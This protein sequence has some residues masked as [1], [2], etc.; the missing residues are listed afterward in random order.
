M[1]RIANRVFGVVAGLLFLTAGCAQQPVDKS[2]DKGVSTTNEVKKQRTEASLTKA[3]TA[4]RKPVAE[5]M[6]NTGDTYQKGEVTT[7]KP[8]TI[9]FTLQLAKTSNNVDKEVL[10][11]VLI[12]GIKP[13]AD[14]IFQVRPGTKLRV[15]LLNP[16]QSVIINQ[17]IS[18]KELK[19]VNE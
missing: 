18:E 8:N 1:T 17:A 12:S 19:T 3:A 6:A 10:K 4:A 11:T 16:D 2:T 14:K 9:V 5:W 15:K 13:A 7:S